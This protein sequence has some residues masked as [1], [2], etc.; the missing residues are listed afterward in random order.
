MGMDVLKC[1]T[2]DRVRKELHM[3][4]LAY[5]LIRALMLEAAVQHGTPP[6][7]LS[8]KESADTIRQ[9]A[10]VLSFANRFSPEDRD[11]ATAA[12]LHYISQNVVPHR[13]NRVEPR[14]RKRRP[15]NHPLLNK[16][17]SQFQEVYHRNKYRAGLHP[18]VSAIRACPLFYSP[19]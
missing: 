19:R 4:I 15:K 16:P 6:L 13:P 14:A 7:R 11:S 17:R 12:L 5:N 9:W 8:F 2:P 3:Y 1:K 10:P 18:Y